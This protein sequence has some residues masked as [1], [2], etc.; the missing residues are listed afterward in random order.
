MNPL[1]WEENRA[2]RMGEGISRTSAEK[3]QLFELKVWLP[4]QGAMRDLVRAESLQQ[5]IFFAENR[6]PNCRIEVPQQTAKPKLVRS[7]TGPKLAARL[8][9]KAMED[10]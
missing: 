4:G 6:Y 8:R 3:T 10:K 5:A 9:K 7:H 2:A 1:Q